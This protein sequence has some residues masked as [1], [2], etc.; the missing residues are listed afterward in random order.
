MKLT[1]HIPPQST[2]SCRSDSS[3]EA[4]S[5]SLSRVESSIISIDSNVT[6][7]GRSLMYSMKRV[8]PRMKPWGTPALTEYSCEDFLSRTTRSCP[9]LRKE[10]IGPNIWP[11]IPQDLSLCWIPAC[12]TLSK[13]LDISS[14]T[15]LVAPDLLKALA[16]LSD[17]TVRRPAVDREDLKPYWKS[18][19][20]SHFF[21]WST[22]LLFTSFAK[23]LLTTKRGLTEW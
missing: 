22:I 20:R 3:S 15:A 18:E 12:R 11:E 1:N 17:T 7:S 10:E 16:I 21:M 23:T 6:S 4:N 8:V 5:S 9:F 2:V 13:A 14:A 19:K